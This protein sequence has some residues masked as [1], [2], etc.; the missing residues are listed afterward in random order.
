METYDYLENVKEDVKEVLEENYSEQLEKLK[1]DEINADWFASKLHDDL[2]VDDCV[3]GNASG[4]YFC[5]SYKAKECV[6][7]ESNKGTNNIVYAVQA[8]QEFY[9]NFAMD[10]ENENWERIDVIIRCWLLYRAINEVLEEIVD[11]D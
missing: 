2:F 4:S 7:G 9:D 8:Y 3:T 5:N 11:E 6:L 10:L 1:N